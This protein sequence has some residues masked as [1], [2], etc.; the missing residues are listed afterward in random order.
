MKIVALKS[1]NVKRLSAIEIK[2]DGNLVVIGGANGAGKSSVLDSI[3]YALAG[4]K[5]L[6]GKPVRDGELKAEIEVRLDGD[7]PLIVKKRI[8]ADGAATLEILQDQG[9]GIVSTMKSPQKVLDSLIGRVAF[10]PLAFTREKPATQVEIL[11]GIVGVD[12]S[13]VDQEIDELFEER[14]DANREVKRLEGL[15]AS[16]PTHEDV[17]IAELSAADIMA[18][19]RQATDHNRDCERLRDVTA[20]A[21][22]ALQDCKDSVADSESEITRLEQ[23]LAKARADLVSRQ[24]S[25]A[26]AAAA[27]EKAKAI[28]TAVTT[29]D[30][31]P[32]EAKLASLE[33]T[34]A[35]VRANQAAAKSREELQAAIDKAAALSAR[36]EERRAARLA[37]MDAATWPVP[38][39]GFGPDGVTF[40]DL[41]FEQCSSAEQLRISTAIAA[42][43][44]PALKVAFI[45]EWSLLDQN[46]RAMVAE[47][48]ESSGLQLWCEE[49]GD[50][51]DAT[52]II[53]AGAVKET[54]P[55]K[56]KELQ[57][58]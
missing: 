15:T 43:Q 24:E 17:G 18:E 37:L 32:I 1:S 16:L 11:K 25:Q 9:N 34:N 57:S 8:K 45:R 29:I 55:A 27:W 36:I 53:E 10:D 40:N 47:I 44:S 56:A 52:V 23:E 22:Q 7:P 42:A 3:L 41:P 35:K 19:M 39:L 50:Q 26:E 51:G 5:S 49:V 48:A 2:P 38:G 14:T 31:A 21:Y 46:T 54:R 58:V 30:L 12:T 6:P 33:Q 28:S 4:G 13:R 20:S